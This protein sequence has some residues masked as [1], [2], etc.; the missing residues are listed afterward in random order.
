MQGCVCECCRDY[1]RSYLYHLINVKEMN[2][3]ILIT[4]HN[5]HL[6]NE[7]IRNIRMNKYQG[8]LGQFYDWFRR[9]QCDP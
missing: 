4:M 1:T 5:V 3:T 6:M 2:A 8:T 7:L 9:T